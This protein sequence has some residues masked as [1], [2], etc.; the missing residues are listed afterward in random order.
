[1]GRRIQKGETS[2]L[3]IGN[4]EIGAFEQGVAKELKILGEN[5]PVAIEI[6]QVPYAPIV[7][8]QGVIRSLVDWRTKEIFKQNDCDAFAMGLSDEIPYAYA[9]KRYDPELKLLYFGKRYYDPTFRRW[10]TPDP[11]G[12]EDHSN[13]Y[14]YL[15]NNPYLYQDDN[16]EF[17][18]VI[19]L[20]FWGAELAVPAISA[21]ITTIVYGA[22]AGAVAYGGYKL[23]E[24]FND[25]GY[26]SIGDYYSGDL[27]PGL[28][29]WSYSTMKSGS[30]DPTLPA[31]PDDLLKKPGWKETHAP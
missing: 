1:M 5:T 14:Q 18:F 22:A 31:N 17:A 7:D 6:N 29:D 19:P 25:R 8:V 15:F 20:L 10:L 26:L 12:P 23:V 13:L 2:F 28:N 11:L 3:Y 30:V 4:E 27:T 16:G 24:T 21:C 9:G